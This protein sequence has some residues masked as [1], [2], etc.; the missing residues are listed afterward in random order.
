MLRRLLALLLLP[1]SLSAQIGGTGTYKFLQ[2]PPSARITALGGNGI[3]LYGSDLNNAYQNPSLLNAQMQRSVVLNRVNYFS[4]IAHGYVAYADK[5]RNIGTFQAGLQYITYGDFAEA[6]ASG[7][8]TGQTL[9]AADYALV[10]GYA[11]PGQYNMQYGA[12]L[13]T[14]YSKLAEYNSYGMAIDAGASYIDSAKRLCAAVVLKNMGMQF[15]GYSDTR[16]ALPFEIQAAISQRLAHAPFRYTLAFTNLQKFDLTYRDPKDPDRETDLAT[17]LPIEKKTSF[18]EKLGRHI[19]GGVELIPSENFI[20]RVGYNYERR[21]ELAVS[22]RGSTVGFSFGVGIRIK[23]IQF[24]YGTAKYHLAG[25][26]HHFSIGIN[27]QEFSK[28][29]P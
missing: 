1:F 19:G 21:R 18:A 24:S 27:L 4:D 6:D 23:K 10:L 28:R 15:K 29:R 22:S 25:S 8:L 12:Q 26:T 2:L 3:A 17:G 9:S 5:M 20:I 13:K 7:N 11:Q 14:I 16:E